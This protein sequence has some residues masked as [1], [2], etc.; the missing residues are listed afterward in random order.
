MQLLTFEPCC[1]AA[2]LP[3]AKGELLGGVDL[4]RLIFNPLA[5]IDILY[6]SAAV[7]S[8]E[9]VSAIANLRIC[10]L[11]YT[12]NHLMLSDY[13]S[14]TSEIY[15]EQRKR[16]KRKKGSVIYVECSTTM[17]KLYIICQLLHLAD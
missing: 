10:V 11:C 5:S 17:A 4:N 8:Q 16:E 7:T 3:G 15:K 1:F 6:Q 9:L 13:W 2:L 14:Y 12:K